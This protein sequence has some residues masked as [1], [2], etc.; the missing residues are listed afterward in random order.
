MNLVYGDEQLTTPTDP[1]PERGDTRTMWLESLDRSV[2]VML[3]G[4]PVKL[5]TGAIG[6][7][8]APEDLVLSTQNGVPGGFLDEVNTTVRRVALP[9]QVQARTQG[10]AWKALAQLRAVVRASPRR[11]TPEGT[12]RLVC[13][14]TSG[15]REL[16][17]AYVSG[18]EGVGDAR[19]NLARF[20]LN[21]V[22]VD[23]FARDAIGRSIT[24]GVDASA[25]PFL[26]TNPANTFGTRKLSSSAVIGQNMAVDIVSEVPVYPRMDFI[27]PQDP[28]TVDVTTGLHVHVPAGVPLGS[29]LTVVTE[30]RF[31]SI[32]LDGVPAAGR[33]SLD[34]WLGAPFEPGRNVMSVAAPGATA[35]S[36]VIVSWRGGWESMW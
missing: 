28:L 12:C 23:P 8:K 1:A 25:G 10:D 13:S 33:L 30:P 15:V 14:S 21:L 24:F 26:S 32:R 4:A 5:L 20:T 18:L 9:M 35:A 6:L 22:A 29:A 7:E 36:K 17:V 16:T 3:D 11:I 31:K 19:P 2:R 27:G 34:S